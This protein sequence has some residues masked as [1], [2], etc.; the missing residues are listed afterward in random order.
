MQ[1]RSSDWNQIPKVSSLSL[2]RSLPYPGILEATRL[3]SLS[4]ISVFILFMRQLNGHG[5]IYACVS[6]EAE[7]SKQTEGVSEHILGLFRLP[8]WFLGVKQMSNLIIT[9]FSRLTCAV[10]CTGLCLH[11]KLQGSVAMW[12]LTNTLNHTDRGQNNTISSLVMLYKSPCPLDW[13]PV[14]LTIVS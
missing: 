8:C 4:E 5:L 11:Q 9:D 3:I 2:P 10:T 1:A 12:S 14:D 6:C 13:A 7:S